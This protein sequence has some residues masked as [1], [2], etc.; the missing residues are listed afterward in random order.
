[1][2]ARDR[3]AP[4][5]HRDLVE[6]GVDVADHERRRGGG[7]AVESGH[8]RPADADAALPHVTDEEPDRGLDLVGREPRQE[9]GEGRDLLRAGTRRADGPRRVD[10][11]GEEHP[12]DEERLHLE[13]LFEA[14][15][16][17]LAAEARLLVAA[18]RRRREVRRPR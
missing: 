1:M 16:A 15:R 9:F 8:R 6:H 14:V 12:S 2:P 13:E 7:R 5:R 4:G 3:S 17:V 11:I 18:E 10:Q